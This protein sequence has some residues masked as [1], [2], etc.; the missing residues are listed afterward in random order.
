MGL[1]HPESVKRLGRKGMIPGKIP[2]IK[3]H[4][5]FK[6]AVDEWIH[7]G[8]K[9]NQ[10][11]QPLESSFVISIRD[12]GGTVLED[13]TR[14][15]ET[16]KVGKLVA[17]T[18]GNSSENVMIVEKICLEVQRCQ[19]YDYAPGIGVRLY[20]F[21]YEVELCPQPGEYVVTEERFKYGR[22]DADDFDVVCMSPHGVEYAMRLNVYWSDLVT[23][24]AF[25][26]HSDTF[27]ICFGKPGGRRLPLAV[28]E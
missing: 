11:N 4:R 21:R 25:A 13:A 19:P 18:L 27:R 6:D 3:E 23:K 24:K 26:S 15:T 10:W 9:A 28:Y 8:G 17:F 20:P 12:T 7:S 22:Y 2:V 1:D 16:R 14:D 5:Y